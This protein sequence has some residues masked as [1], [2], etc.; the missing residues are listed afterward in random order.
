[1]FTPKFRYT[2]KIVNNLMKIEG[3]KEMI[4]NSPIIPIW[5]SRL[6]KDA[7]V[8]MAHHTTHIEGTQL[9]KEQVR[10]LIDGKQVVARE[11]D[12]QEVFNYLKVI[13]F[14]D[15]VYSD[16]EMVIDLRTIRHIHRLTM[17]GLKDGYEAGEY[18]KVQNYV[19]DS[20]TGKIIYTPP[21]A[22][23]V[24]ILMMELIDWLRSEE[25]SDLPNV[26]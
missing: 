12:K 5:Q 16:P 14:I 10:D 19:V 25:A 24:P 1:M 17:E 3:A 9:T 8:R 26:S 6:Q 2:H 4:M 11:R 13:S 23:E 7:L 18:R 15:E 21:P 22:N 20:K